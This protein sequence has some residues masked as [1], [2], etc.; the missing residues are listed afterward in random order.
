MDDY[1][2]ELGW[3]DVLLLFIAVLSVI[4]LISGVISLL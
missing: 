1:E 2:N 4:G 3:R